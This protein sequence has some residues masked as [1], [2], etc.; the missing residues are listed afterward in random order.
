[1]SNRV[2]GGMS[3]DEAC[4]AG[5]SFLASMGLFG[6]EVVV[7]GC[8]YLENDKITYRVSPD[9][10]EIHQFHN[11]SVYQNLYPTSVSMYNCRINTSSDLQEEINY[12]AKCTMARHLHDDYPRLFFDLLAPLSETPANNSSFPL[13]ASMADAIDGY[14]DDFELQLLEGTMAQCY[15]AKL[16]DAN[17]HH[18]LQQWIEKTRQQMENA[19]VLQA[20]YERTFYGFCYQD[21]TGTIKHVSN[22]QYVKAKERH[23]ASLATGC[24]TGPLMEQTCWMS[25]LGQ[26]TFLKQAFNK[27]LL[28]TQDEQYF[29]LLRT[30]SRLPSVIDR[31][32]FLTAL[33]QLEMLP[34]AK[35]VSDF[36]AYGQRW[37]VRLSEK[38]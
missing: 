3:R 5:A 23:T 24:L 25:D 37:Q 34:Y 21:A 1:M 14:F 18:Q 30:I 8:A 7:Y 19:P 31:D 32:A 4:A 35:A 17:N 6:N 38:H 36:K 15:Q 20:Q 10:K 9:G 27:H 26:I 2:T 33:R 12:E 16:L 11:A 22:A 29:S 28:T 13:L